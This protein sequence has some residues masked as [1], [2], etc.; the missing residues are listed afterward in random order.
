MCGHRGFTQNPRLLGFSCSSMG[1]VAADPS[2]NEAR[3]THL[4]AAAAA[5]AVSFLALPRLDP[6]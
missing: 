3:L 1:R 2:S 6:K 4:V 5:S